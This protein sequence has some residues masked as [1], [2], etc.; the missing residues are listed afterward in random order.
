LTALEILEFEMNWCN[1]A[2]VSRHFQAIFFE[3]FSPGFYL[4]GLRAMGYSWLFLVTDHARPMHFPYFPCQVPYKMRRQQ[5]QAVA[6]HGEADG[7]L[8]YI[9]PPYIFFGEKHID[10]LWI[11]YFISRCILTN[12]FC[13]VLAMF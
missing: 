4:C 5:L 3:L 10:M 2:N 8:A 12:K 9:F 11:I 7:L 13:N 6:C 1:C